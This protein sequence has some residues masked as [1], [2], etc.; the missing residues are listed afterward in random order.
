MTQKTQE[1]ENTTSQHLYLVCFVSTLEME[2]HLSEILVHVFLTRA[3][4]LFVYCECIYVWVCFSNCV[5]VLLLVEQQLVVLPLR[6]LW[7]LGLQRQW[8]LLWTSQ[9]SLFL[10]LQLI[11]SLERHSTDLGE[12][13]S[14]VMYLISF[15]SLMQDVSVLS[16]LNASPAIND[17]LPIYL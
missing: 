1:K 9:A 14:S 4:A 17:F 7:G 10:P 6:H 11:L 3:K 16:V 5:Y 13:Q 12:H 15:F 2:T 8:F